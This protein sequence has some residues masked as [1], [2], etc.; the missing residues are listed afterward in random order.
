MICLTYWSINVPSFDVSQRL[1]V[2]APWAF[3]RLVARPKKDGTVADVIASGTRGREIAVLKGSSLFARHHKR[4]VN[5]A[6]RWDRVSATLQ[7]LRH[8]RR[9]LLMSHFPLFLALFL[10]SGCRNAASYSLVCQL[11]K[12]SASSTV[13]DEKTFTWNMWIWFN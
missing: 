6:W 12:Q 5:S 9:K 8:C 10:V 1:E 11:S 2:R 7:L 3:E 4:P 13:A